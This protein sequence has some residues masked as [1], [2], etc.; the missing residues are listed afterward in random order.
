M[1]ARSLAKKLMISFYT[2]VFQK[3]PGPLT[4]S[5]MKNLMYIFVGFI[6]AK[7]LSVV[8]QI[9]TGRIIGPAEY[10]KFAY[11]N[12][13]AQILYTPMMFGIG[14]A[15]VKYL[16]EKTDED[17]RRR[18]VSSGIAL[19]L[20]FT[21]AFAG[22]FYVLAAPISYS[23]SIAQNYVYAAII[24]AVLYS[25]WTASQKL[26]QGLMGMR[27]ISILNIIWSVV[28][29]VTVV[30]Y[31]GAERTVYA[32]L[33]AVSLGYVISSVVA[34]PSLVR[35]FRPRIDAAWTRKLLKFGFIAVWA[36]LSVSMTTG[37]NQIFINMF[38]DMAD[39]G[40]Y[41]AYHFS[42]VDVM[43]FFLTGF[44][45]VFFAESSRY[46][47]KGALFSQLRKSMKL[48][49]LV[50]AAML[51]I[52][53]SI[54]LLYGRDYPIS[55]LLLCLFALASVAAF[56]QGVYTWFSTSHGMKGVK[57]TT[58]T[59]MLVSIVNIAL[60]YALIQYLSIA[61]AALSLIFS[62]SMGAMIMYLRIKKVSCGPAGEDGG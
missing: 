20:L 40:I 4:R 15:L 5:F 1:K 49:P 18:I 35:Y 42:S 60:S 38:M 13:L 43:S 46:K 24:L 30:L 39:V 16:S 17:E 27:E 44:I 61:G 47:N 50:F 36:S 2:K 37:I 57:I 25:V 41:Q 11:I 32:P 10:G 54:L 53:Y 14:T 12:S 55:P 3:E 28:V 8:F 6:I 59:V 45:T 19:M 58:T 9:Y 22:A 48:M 51:L 62:Y 56:L 29:L 52:S 21:L 23:A 26:L 31:T 7:A 33:L 34:L